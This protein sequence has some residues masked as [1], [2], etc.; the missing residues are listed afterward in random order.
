MFSSIY[1]KFHFARLPH[2]PIAI[3]FSLLV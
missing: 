3:F 1:V 2:F